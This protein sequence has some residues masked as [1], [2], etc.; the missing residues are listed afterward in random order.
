GSAMPTFEEWVTSL[1]FAVDELSEQQSAALQIAYKDKYPEGGSADPNPDDPGA[2]GNPPPVPAAALANDL[3]AS[4]QQAAA[5][6]ERRFAINRLCANAGNPTLTV[7]NRAT[8]LEA[9]AIAEGWDTNRTELEI[10]RLSRPQGPAIISREHDVDCSLQA[11]QGALILRAN[12]RLDH[13][14]YRGRRALAMGIPAWLRA[15]INDARRNQIMENA[16]RYSDMSA[17]DFCREFLR[18]DGRD[19]PHGRSNIIRAA[20]SGSSL[21]NIFTTNVNAILLATYEEADDTTAGWTQE[22]D[23]NDFKTQ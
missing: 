1:G 2:S 11:L 16:H 8:P 3:Q 4:R 17:I 13:P 22:T 15:G 12:G 20:F 23:V 19:V 7:Q 21:T 10:L 6:V 9:H 5:E 14:S 18:L